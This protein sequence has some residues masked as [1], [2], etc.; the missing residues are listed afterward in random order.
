MA[1]TYVKLTPPDN[2]KAIIHYKEALR[3]GERIL[4]KS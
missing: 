3:L 4:G 2:E 1:N